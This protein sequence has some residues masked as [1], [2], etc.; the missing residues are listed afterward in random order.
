LY[1]HVEHGIAIGEDAVFRF[2]PL[3]DIDELLAQKLSECHVLLRQKLYQRC[4]FQFRAQQVDEIG[5][6]FLRWM[7]E[8]C[9][10]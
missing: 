4:S 6:A 8:E 10:A 3:N 2:I 9:P 5:A 7:H 1:L